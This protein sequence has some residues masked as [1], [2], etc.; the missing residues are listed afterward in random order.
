MGHVPSRDPEELRESPRLEVRRPIVRAHCRA[1]AATRRAPAARDVMMREHPCPLPQAGDAGADVRDDP[2]GLVSDH[3]RRGRVRA[4]DLLEVGAAQPAGAH[5]DDDFAAA[6]ARG[7][8]V[9][10]C[11][12]AGP[13]E[14]CGLHGRIEG[15][16]RATDKGLSGRTL[17][18]TV[19]ANRGRRGRRRLCTHESLY[20]YS[21]PHL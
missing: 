9:L 8:D 6:R 11:D 5:L 14:E 1:P 12:A 2:D 15:G 7:G 19:S 20:G 13:S 18:S 3:G 4:A 10:D 16:R 21:R 17:T